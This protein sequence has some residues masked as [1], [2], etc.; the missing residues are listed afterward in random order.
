MKILVLDDDRN[1]LTLMDAILT[2][3]GH[4]VTCVEDAEKAVT[5][6]G[7]QDYD[8]VL[9]DYQMEGKTGVWFMEHANLPP[10]TKAL[11]VTGNVDRDV[12]TNMFDLGAAGYIIKPFGEEELLRH[13]GFHGK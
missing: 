11:L 12:I 3:N 13:I 4:E 8:F 10:K 5:L 1:L 6:V 2:R 7:E 9:V